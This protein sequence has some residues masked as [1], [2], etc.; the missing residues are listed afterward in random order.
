MK[1]REHI[2]ENSKI[3][4]KYSMSRPK[5]YSNNNVNYTFADRILGDPAVLIA[6]STLAKKELGWKPK[7]NKLVDIVK[8]VWE[9]HKKYP[10][11]YN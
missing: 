9:W 5:K 10:F 7:F 1:N 8:S 6:S 2:I 3:V 11:G 4:N